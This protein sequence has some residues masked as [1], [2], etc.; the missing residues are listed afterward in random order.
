MIKRSFLFK[1]FIGLLI[2]INPCY[3]QNFS[4]GINT[5]SPNSNAALDIQNSATFYQGLLIP[6][7]NSSALLKS[8]WNLK[9]ADKGLIFY[10]ENKDSIYYWNGSV[11]NCLSTRNGG[12]IWT[13]ANSNVF[14]TSNSDFVRIGSLKTQN[15]MF[16][17]RDSLSKTAIYAEN[18]LGAYGIRGICVESP[19]QGTGGYFSG[20]SIGIEGSSTQNGI[21]T[22]IGGKF[23]ASNSTK[24]Y[25]G[26]FLAS[27]A[28][29]ATAIYAEV[30]NVADFNYAGHFVG[31]VF[32]KGLIGIG[33]PVPRSPIDAVTNT[34][35]RCIAG[36]NTNI[37]NLDGSSGVYG[38]RVAKDLSNT[39]Y[40]VH[41]EI[42][43]NQGSGIGKRAGVFG[44]VS[45]IS[46][47]N[48]GLWGKMGAGGD[49]N[50]AIYGEGDVRIDGDLIVNGSGNFTGLVSKPGGTFKIDH[51]LD[52]QNKFLFHSFVESPDMMN[53]YNGN[54]TTGQDGVARVELPAYFQSLNKD[55]RYQLTVIGKK[56]SAFISK[57][58]HDNVFY[59]TTD[60]PDTKISWQVTGI[61][62]DAY[63]E[64][65]RIKNEV[66]K[67]PQEKGKYLYPDVYNKSV[68]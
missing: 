38:Y 45:G 24:V 49:E 15:A 43:G 11:W 54:I 19:G 6:R 4:N 33:R 67:L 17:V 36:Y 58:I 14:L 35:F 55:F 26:Y 2:S 30:D 31:N 68:K 12:E 51:P 47:F 60:K 23:S 42:S 9:P 28:T 57:E 48:T 5:S 10:A 34:L 50:Y 29:N 46:A 63:A 27:L 18:T 62:K 65:Y 52:P 40:G 59:I 7:L 16:S 20:A 53:I 61:R 39:S 41:G 64:K 32:V 13:K 21:N 8:N 3:G 56:A 66:D 37:D 1:F 44:E 25:A 22:A